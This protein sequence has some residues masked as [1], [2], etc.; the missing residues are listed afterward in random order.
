[1]A[2]YIEA[3]HR[4]NL[5]L[6]FGEAQINAFLNYI[7]EKHYAVTTI[8]SHFHTIQLIGKE[9][10]MKPSPHNLI[11]YKFVHDHGK[12][13]KDKKLPVSRQLLLQLCGGADNMLVGYTA[14]LAKTMFLCTWL[15]SM[16][17][18]KFLCT[19]AKMEVFKQ[20]HNVTSTVGLS[21]CFDS[22]KISK[23]DPSVQHRT[24]RWHKLPDFTKEVVDIYVH[25]TV[26]RC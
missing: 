19:K 14:I 9:L 24:V 18:S 6:N 25:I 3:C 15:F 12:K 22:D 1:M 13:M 16:H 20:S 4:E 17:I 8:S 23:F 2:N 5:P 10:N 11:K 26:T 7:Y 21:A